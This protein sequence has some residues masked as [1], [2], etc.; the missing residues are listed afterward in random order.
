LNKQSFGSAQRRTLRHG[1]RLTTTTLLAVSAALGCEREQVADRATQPQPAP[2]LL[3][4]PS[5]SATGV[6]QEDEAKRKKKKAD[7]T[8]R[9]ARCGECHEKMYEEW[10]LSSHAA[11]AKSAVY[12]AMRKAPGATGCERCHT[13]LQAL[14]VGSDTARHEGVTCEVCHRIE[15]VQIGARAASFSLLRTH[16]IKFGP[17]CELEDPYFHRAR[18]SPLF[19]RSELCASCHLLSHELGTGQAALP[20]HTEYEDWKKTRFAAKGKT[21]QS[22]HMPGERAS[23]ATGEPERE[24]VPDHGFLGA[25]QKLAGTALTAT[26]RVAWK[27]GRVTA[28]VLVT[29]ARAGHAIPAGS[30]GSE[31]VVRA[32]A[33]DAEA[34]EIERVERVFARTLEDENGRS[35]PFF[36]AVNVRSDTR[37]QPGTT[38]SEALPIDVPDVHELR[39]TILSRPLGP[40]LAARL[41][42]KVEEKVLASTSFTA[43]KGGAGHRSV[44]MLR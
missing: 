38:R 19:T 7:Q 35:A 24:G 36:H 11:A 17:R 13:P 28:T 27:D 42:L 22:C 31:V 5:G 40:E 9:A 26:A 30:P 32:V 16:E 8:H 10:K 1:V 6:E 15:S 21:C 23:L 29:N 41:E 12:E 3:A 4:A 25:A 33:V 20:V 43:P 18:C 34:R 44:V 2:T 37:I 14:D 39:V